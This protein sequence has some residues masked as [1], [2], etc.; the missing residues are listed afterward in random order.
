MTNRGGCL[1]TVCLH[2]FVFGLVGYWA[3]WNKSTPFCAAQ[4]H[5]TILKLFG[6]SHLVG[7][8]DTV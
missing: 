4:L 7:S 8:D 3:F 1:R 5:K 6:E 2:K